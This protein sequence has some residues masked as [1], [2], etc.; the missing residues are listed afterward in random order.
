M[1]D[2]LYTRIR[3]VFQ[4]PDV[5]P[6]PQ[7]DVAWAESSRIYATNSFNKYNPDE[8]IG[9]K[10]YAIYRKMMQ[11]EQVKAAVKFKRDAIT[12]RDFFFELDHEAHGLTKDEAERRIALSYR[13]I[14]N[15]RGSWMDALNGIM[16]AYYNGFSMSEKIFGQ[17]EFSNLTWWGIERLNLKPY[18]TFFFNTDEFGN[19]IQYI[20]QMSGKEQELDPEKFIHYVVNPDIDEHYGG[21]ELREAYR[22]WFSKDAVIKFRNM[23]LERHA[24]G[25]RR[26][27]VKDGQTISPNSAE[28]LSIQNV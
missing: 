1:T 14:E 26:I 12:S 21:S 11:D 8:L 7:G 9:R 19:I 13:I 24:G 23:W 28:Y 5:P 15:M 3:A 17:F 20:Q 18:D 6:P 27:Q 25:F 4:T 10:G 16:S 2:N 22:A